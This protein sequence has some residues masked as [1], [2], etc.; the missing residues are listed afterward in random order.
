MVT[1]HFTNVIRKSFVSDYIDILNSFRKCFPAFSYEITDNMPVSDKE[2]P[3]GMFKEEE[4]RRLYVSASI[5]D[6]A[7]FVVCETERAYHTMCLSNPLSPVL[8]G[9]FFQ[10]LEDTREK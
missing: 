9:G 3:A 10:E 4:Y 1:N 2:L 6:P 5:C 8:K 7:P